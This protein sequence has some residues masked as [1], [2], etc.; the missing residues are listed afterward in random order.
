MMVT[1]LSKEW[2]ACLNADKQQP[3]TY[4]PQLLTVHAIIVVIG[5]R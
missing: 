2:T 5:L 3:A 1:L 4:T